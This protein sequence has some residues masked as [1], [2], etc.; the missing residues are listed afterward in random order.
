[1][2]DLILASSSPRRRQLLALAGWVFAV[3]SVDVDERSLSGENAPDYVLRLARL[4]ASAAADRLVTDLANLGN[5]D[6]EKLVIA[7]DTTVV[8]DGL[9][10]GKPRHAGDARQMLRRLRG[11][12]HQ[13]Y[14][15]LA[16]LRLDDGV[17]LTDL[18]VTD[19]LMRNYTDAEIEAYIQSG[20]PFDKAGA[21]A[22]QHMGFCPV[23]RLEGC[24]ANVVGLPLCHLARLL[25]GLNVLS[26]IDLPR[27]CQQAFDYT[28]S[29][30]QN[31]Y[32]PRV[33]PRWG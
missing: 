5:L 19:V 16:V 23:E 4:K 6:G 26:K 24:Y 31:I 8:D 9:L 25:D 20:D 3:V 22:I 30:F 7:A 29:V 1:M 13:V 2:T 14:S 33:F 15:A 10:L 12:T 27:A 32:Q 21:Y 11:R 28:C 18:C 17:L